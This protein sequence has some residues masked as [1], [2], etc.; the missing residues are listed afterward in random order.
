QHHRKQGRLLAAMHGLSRR[1]Y[2]GGF[3]CEGAAQPQR[4]CTV[5]EVFERR[6]HVAEPGGTAQHE[7]T[8][9]TQIVVRRVRRTLRRNARLRLLDHG[10]NRRN[11]AQPGASPRDRFDA[12]ADM[13]REFRRAAFAR[14]KQDEYFDHAREFSG[15]YR[16]S[17]CSCGTNATRE[18]EDDAMHCM[19]ARL[20]G[21]A[22]PLLRSIR[23]CASRA[24]YKINPP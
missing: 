10:V 2:G 22:R 20:D 6:G 23:S 21:V 14:I 3:V 7:P 1:E 18:S 5:D 11:G 9:F 12:A 17:A 15:A 8:T 13:A 24:M 4:A 19:D 16:S